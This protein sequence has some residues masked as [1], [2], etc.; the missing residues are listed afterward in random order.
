MAGTSNVSNDRIS[1]IYEDV[2]SITTRQLPEIEQHLAQLNGTVREHSEDITGLKG[3]F[4]N[5]PCTDNTRTMIVLGEAVKHL[6]E[7][8]GEDHGTMEKWLD[9]FLTL[10]Q[11]LLTAWLLSKLL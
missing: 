6:T 9:R 1:E 4:A 3:Q 8:L 10:A 5:L 7:K 11:A 2:K